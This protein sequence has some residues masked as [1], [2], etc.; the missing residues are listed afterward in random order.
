MQDLVKLRGEYNCGLFAVEFE[1]YQGQALDEKDF[2]DG[3]NVD[4]EVN[5]SGQ[6]KR[7]FTILEPIM[8]DQIDKT[9]EVYYT[10]SL[11]DYPQIL[12]TSFFRIHYILTDPCDINLISAGIL[13]T[14]PRSC[15]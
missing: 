3:L 5:E 10:V 1:D 7:N 6:E 13:L 9:V 8:K 14:L 11:L 15:K 2:L 12:A 4:I